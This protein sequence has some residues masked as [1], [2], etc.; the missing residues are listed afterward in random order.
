MLTWNVMYHCKSGQ[1]DAFYKAVSDLGARENSIHEEG[2]L[3]YDYYFDAQDPDIL[4]LVETST[5]PA[6]QAAHCQ[7]EIFAKL[8]EL[9]AQ[10][11]ENV[12]IEKF[13]F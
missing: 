7:T 3:R 13:N 6:L 11:C 1:R 5:E 12:V 2:N 8:Q 10:Y 4:L 9:K